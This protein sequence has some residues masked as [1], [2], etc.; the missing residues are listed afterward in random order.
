[1]NNVHKCAMWIVSAIVA[2]TG[3]VI[4]KNLESATWIMMIPLAVTIFTQ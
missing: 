1:M 4:T 2:I 3:I